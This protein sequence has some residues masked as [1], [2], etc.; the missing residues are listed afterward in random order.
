MRKKGKQY[1]K[2]GRMRRSLREGSAGRIG[3]IREERVRNVVRG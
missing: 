3:G 2:M 1:M